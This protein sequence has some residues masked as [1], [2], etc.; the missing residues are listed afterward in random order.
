MSDSCL[1]KGQIYLYFSFLAYLH[2][3]F[4]KISNRSAFNYLITQVWQA[5]KW[6]EFSLERLTPYYRVGN[7][8]ITCNVFISMFAGKVL[9]PVLATFDELTDKIK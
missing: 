1:H 2:V 8:T 9:L 3:K 7:R 5:S 4:L 6:E